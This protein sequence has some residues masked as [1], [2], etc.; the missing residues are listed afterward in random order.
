MIDAY[1]GLGGN[2]GDREMQINE[3][4]ARL[5]QHAQIAVVAV[6]PM[7]ETKPVGYVEQPDFLNV[8]VH[9]QTTLS[10]TELLDVGLEVEAALHRVRDVRWGP[11]TIDIDVLLYGQDVIET[12]RVTVPHP[13]MT[14]RAFVMIPLNDIAP[15]VI[16][17]RSGKAIRTLVK[18][19]ETVIRYG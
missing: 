13:R 18:P 3:A 12:E 6:S 4:I 9:V 14:E 16:E 19:D 2:I 1:L 8:C 15:D 7:Y 11:R 5:D 10:A 17:P